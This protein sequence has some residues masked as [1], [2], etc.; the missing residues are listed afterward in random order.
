LCIKVRF[1]NFERTKLPE[2]ILKHNL[3]EKRKYFSDIH[4]DVE[5]SDAEVQAEGVYNQR[6]Q[7]LAVT[8]DKVTTMSLHKFKHNIAL[9]CLHTFC[10]ILK[11]FSQT[12]VVSD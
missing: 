1:I 4:L 2:E 8:L 12:K 6:L 11:C 10:A 9:L 7:N 5:K 3:E